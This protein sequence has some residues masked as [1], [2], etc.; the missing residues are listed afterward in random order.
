MGNSLFSSS[1]NI[2]AED[3]Y[4]ESNKSL[5]E[6]ANID[7]TC[8]FTEAIDYLNNK[9]N[10][11]T[12]NSISLYESLYNSNN[13]NTV[14]L[15]SFSEYFAKTSIIL[16]ET[17][18]FI[19]DKLENFIDNMEKRIEYNS[20]IKENKK[21]LEEF[22]SIEP[23]KFDDLYIFTIDPSIPDT[24]VINRFCDSVFDDLFKDSI[25]DCSIE[26]I[27]NYTKNIDIEKDYDAFRG[28]ILLSGEPIIQSKFSM[29]LYKI[30]RNGCATRDTVYIDND[31]YK[32][33][34]D[35]FFDFSSTKKELKESINATFNSF[36]G[37]E[38]KISDICKNNNGLTVGAFNKLMP[39]DMVH[40]DKISNTTTDIE[41]MTMPADMLLQLDIY[42]KAKIDQLQKYTDFITMALMAKMDAYRD[43]FLQD[44]RVL[45]SVLSHITKDTEIR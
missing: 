37:L 25:M 4:I 1:L 45:L 42:C 40:M 44:R 23:M 22:K 19:N 10:R 14:V 41:G 34:L 2:L 27:E 16:D 33:I 36:K 30:F 39:G 26:S 28:A 15:E 18:D 3:D 32:E 29:E 7:N 13:D 20:S 35:R 11:Y 21:Q 12:K 9:N 31:F 38:K 5:K 6:M 8:Y 17:K 43:R 24:T